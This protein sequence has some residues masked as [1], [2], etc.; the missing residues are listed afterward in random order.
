MAY[1]VPSKEKVPPM[2]APT[3]PD[4]RLSKSHS[5][6]G[7]TVSPGAEVEVHPAALPLDVIVILSLA[8]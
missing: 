4:S 1:L 3:T 8:Q 6:V 7:G 5:S 2:M